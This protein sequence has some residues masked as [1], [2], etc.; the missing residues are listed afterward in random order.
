MNCECVVD[1]LGVS[2]NRKRKNQEKETIIEGKGSII[3]GKEE[4]IIEGK[5][6]ITE[7]RVPVEHLPPTSST[8]PNSRSS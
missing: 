7:Q 3:E 1:G 6:T 4:T 5:E 8:P 2:S